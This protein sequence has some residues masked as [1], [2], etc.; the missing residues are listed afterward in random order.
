MRDMG[1]SGR[2]LENAVQGEENGLGGG[3]LGMV[4]ESAVQV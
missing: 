1:R 4:P 3:E 2:V